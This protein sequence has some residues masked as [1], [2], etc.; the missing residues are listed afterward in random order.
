MEIRTHRPMG[1]LSFKELAQKDAQNDAIHESLVL[2]D[3][4]EAACTNGATLIADI[5]HFEQSVDEMSVLMAQ[6]RSRRDYEKRNH[7]DENFDRVL[8]N[9]VLHKSWQIVGLVNAPRVNN[10]DLLN[11]VRKLFPDESDLVLVLRE[12]LQQQTIEKKVLERLK[13]L[14]LQVEKQSEDR[15]LKAGINCALK[16]RLFGKIM[17]LRPSVLRACYR[18]FLQSSTPEIVVYTDWICSYGFKRRVQVLEF[19]ESALLADITSQDAS[20]SQLEF[21]YLLGRIGQLRRLRSAEV[22]F[23]HR[24][25]TSRIACIFCDQE[26]VWLLLMLSLLQQSQNPN[27]LLDD[28][29]NKRGLFNRYRHK[30]SVFLQIL[31]QACKALPSSLFIEEDGQTL[32]LDGLRHIAHVAY[33]NELVDQHQGGAEDVSH[34]LLSLGD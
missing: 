8:D 23:I 19:V 27:Q 21:S 14:L 9:D 32:L 4:K 22:V 7:F 5:E 17:N 24:L 6:F 29:V 3:E 33:Q 15:V 26:D 34:E 25:L 11:Q 2:E 16:A 18:H 30:Y 31:Y 20:C 12:L 13:T 10:W 1:V 28:I